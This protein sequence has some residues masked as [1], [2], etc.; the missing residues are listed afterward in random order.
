M[1]DD[2]T[3][4]A[5]G[6]HGSGREMDPIPGLGDLAPEP[7]VDYWDAI[8][9][10]LAAVEA[11][12]AE[13]S[14]GVEVLGVWA[15]RTSSDNRDTDDG[16]IRLD[17][18]ITQRH[19]QNGRRFTGQSMMA[20]A[21]G[22]LL[23]VLGGLTLNRALTNGDGPE[24]VQAAGGDGEGE[25]SVGV[26]SDADA[27]ADADADVDA[28][29]SDN[30]TPAD[31]Q[32]QSAAL[33]SEAACYTGDSSSMVIVQVD[34]ERTAEAE[35]ATQDGLGVGFELRAYEAADDGSFRRGAVGTYF[36]DAGWEAQMTEIDGDG[37][38]SLR[39]S[40]WSISPERVIR[41]EG[42]AALEVTD[43]SEVDNADQLY[44]EA[45]SLPAV[46][47]LDGEEAAG[48]LDNDAL[49]HVFV[50]TQLLGVW[51]KNTETWNDV[52]PGDGG[53]LFGPADGFRVDSLQTMATDHNVVWQTS[54]DVVPTECGI[55]RTDSLGLS[56]GSRD[57][58]HVHGTPHRTILPQL[59]TEIPVDDTHLAD[60]AQVLA[61]VELGQVNA[62]VYQFDIEG[63]GVDEVLI[64]ATDGGPA[65]YSVLILRRVA[66]GDVERVIVHR[67]VLSEGDF[68]DFETSTVVA[69]ADINGDGNLDLA[70][71]DL[72]F[73]NGGAGVWELT[74]TPRKVL[75]QL[76]GP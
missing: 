10:R 8:D 76:C 75:S 52:E 62:R 11:E 3:P 46:E 69:I 34:V 29:S 16:V 71:L 55:D 13:S 72:V 19:Y 44:D 40:E 22:L 48:P 74:G 28:E 66:A 56:R 9:A 21:A 24:A 58:L 35:A 51:D 36:S 45:L 49:V 33:P 39:S 17:D 41:G 47:S 18:M 20:V 67:S 32:E 63:D 1:S 31:D 70:T 30:S 5:S 61:G 2:L 53:D 15:E 26:T 60:I 12:Q 54:T 37:D 4:D 68:F 25:T 50:G 73:E 14:D 42:D 64:E 65:G 59:V 57:A 23:L 43:C 38:Q 27:D 6:N 7:G